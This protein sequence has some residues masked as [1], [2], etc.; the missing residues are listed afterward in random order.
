MPSD[1]LYTQSRAVQEDRN[2]ILDILNEAAS[3]LP[4]TSQSRHK[5]SHR[6]RIARNSQNESNR[7][8]E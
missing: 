8:P 4:I 1:I 7:L 6:D 2:T 5:E 3:L